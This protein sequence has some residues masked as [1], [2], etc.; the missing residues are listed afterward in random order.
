VG[1]VA[2]ARCGSSEKIKSKIKSKSKIKRGGE[3]RI[4]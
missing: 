2:T 4:L 3:I 1:T